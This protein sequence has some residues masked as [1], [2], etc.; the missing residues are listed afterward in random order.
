[1][2]H[3]PVESHSGGKATYNYIFAILSLLTLL[4]LAVAELV[5][6]G[7]LRAIVILIFT[8]GKAGLVG[9]YYMHLKYDPP[10]LTWMFVGAMIIATAVVISLQRL[11]VY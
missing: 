4:E 3:S 6:G 11:G 5:A 9:A 1:M 10:I 2:Q 7:E 8:T